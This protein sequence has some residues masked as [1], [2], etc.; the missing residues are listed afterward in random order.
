M[1]RSPD[2]MIVYLTM[3]VTLSSEFGKQIIFDASVV[4]LSRSHC[5]WPNE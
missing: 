5:N 3:M 1:I 4:L 2:S